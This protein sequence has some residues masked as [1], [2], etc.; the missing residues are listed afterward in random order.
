M[1]WR[2]LL[3]I[4]INVACLL[5]A[6][7]PSSQIASCRNR[8]WLRRASIAAPIAKPQLPKIKK[9]RAIFPGLRS[10]DLCKVSA[11]FRYQEAAISGVTSTM[12]RM[13]PAVS[14]NLHIV[15]MFMHLHC[16]LGA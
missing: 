11:C 4:T 14:D 9:L 8:S 15:L 1:A 6:A 13:Y 7:S 2:Q 5:G 3:G 12:I 10:L 16:R